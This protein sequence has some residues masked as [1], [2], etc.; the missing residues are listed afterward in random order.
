M[1]E[2]SQSDFL[3]KVGILKMLQLS[4]NPVEM[5]MVNEKV[6]VCNLFDPTE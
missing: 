6:T 1:P 3:P 4:P 5:E 2:F